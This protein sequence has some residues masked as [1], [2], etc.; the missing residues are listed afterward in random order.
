MQAANSGPFARPLALLI[1][2]IVC[3]H[4]FAC[5]TLPTTL[6]HST[7]LICS[8][9][10]SLSPEFMG[11]KCLSM[12]WRRPFHT[13]S[14]HCALQLLLL[15]LLFSLCGDPEWRVVTRLTQMA[16]KSAANGYLFRATSL[17]KRKIDI[18]AEREQTPLPWMWLQ[19]LLCR[20]SLS[21]FEVFIYINPLT[22]TL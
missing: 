20:R 10:H 4:A 9:A 14:T 15:L 19:T 18:R 6:T 21:L 22:H 5:S 13:V 17:K 1:A 12:M 11:K 7:A 2:L 8:L 3:L 16:Q